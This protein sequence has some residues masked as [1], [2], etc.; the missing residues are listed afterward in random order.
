MCGLA[1]GFILVGTADHAVA[2][3]LLQILMEKSAIEL[4]DSNMRFLAL[5]IA[6]IFLG[7]FYC[8]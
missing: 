7:L 4:L 5:G 8:D 3:E 6:L 1:L 2:T